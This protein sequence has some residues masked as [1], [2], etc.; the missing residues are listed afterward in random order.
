MCRKKIFFRKFAQI[1][2]AMKK[3]TY[4]GLTFEPY[5]SHQTL[6]TRVAEIA[7]Q[8]SQDYSGKC[9]LFICVLTGAFMFASDLFKALDIDAEITFIRLKSYEGTSTTGKIKEVMGLHESIEGR[10]I[11]I[12]EDIVDTGNTIVRLI[13]DLK[14]QG[15]ASIKVAT[16]LFKPESIQFDYKPDYVGFPI[17][18]KFIIG[19][20]L[21]LDGLARNLPD[22]YS[23]TNEE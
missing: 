11:I 6:Q 20:G 9:P 10:D 18:T 15:A 8:I 7:G 5:I 22:I 3:V 17:P 12:V 14:Q 21:D 19:Y 4:K 16:L 23:L 2:L 1:Y 13:D